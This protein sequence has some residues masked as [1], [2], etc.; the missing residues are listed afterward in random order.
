MGNRPQKTPEFFFF[1][2]T[3]KEGK[4]QEEK[5]IDGSSYLNLIS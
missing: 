2:C 3:G 1:F 5:D 4:E